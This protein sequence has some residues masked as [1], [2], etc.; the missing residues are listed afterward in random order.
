MQLIDVMFHSNWNL[1]LTLTSITNSKPFGSFRFLSKIHSFCIL[2]ETK[3]FFPWGPATVECVRY[4]C[5][6]GEIWSPLRYQN[7]PT[8]TSKIVSFI[9]PCSVWRKEGK[10]F[11]SKTISSFSDSLHCWLCFSFLKTHS[12][13]KL[14]PKQR[15][16]RTHCK[17]K[18][19]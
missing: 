10:G 5:P 7:P 14:I 1:T 15:V 16:R 17:K 4:S 6:C 12:G 9:F 18:P 11:K 2:K 13:N 8:H 19:F 3:K